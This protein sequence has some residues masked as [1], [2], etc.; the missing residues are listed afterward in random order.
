MGSNKYI[1]YYENNFDGEATMA[2]DE[3]RLESESI[4][5]KRFYRRDFLASATVVGGIGLAGCA[6]GESGSGDSDSGGSDSDSTDSNSDEE[7]ESEVASVELASGTQGTNAYDSGLG[8]LRAVEEHSDTL[9]L[10]I[11]EGGG[12]V[13]QAYL[14][15]N[16]E[17]NA[18]A[19]NNNTIVQAREEKGPFADEAVDI[20]PAQAHWFQSSHI[21]FLAREGSGVESLADIDDHSVYPLQPGWGARELTETILEEAGIAER[22]EYVNLDIGDMPGALA[23]GRVDV[24][25]ITAA[26]MIQWGGW[27][28]EMDVRNDLY[29]VETTDSYAQA[30][31]NH[32]G[33]RH[34]VMEPYGW[35]QDVT[36]ITNE[37]DTIVNDAQMFFGDEVSA[38]AVRELTRI[39]YEH[40]D[41]IR[42]AAKHYPE[43]D[44]PEE[45][46]NAVIK[47]HPIHEGAAEYYKEQEIWNDDW[48]IGNVYES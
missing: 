2:K 36:K 26:N 15:G 9:D 23:E 5:N 18:V 7:A 40:Q 37:I 41:T 20:V 24:T 28:Q 3:E 47:D 38:Q 34:I 25:A 48:T 44:G 10:T 32:P 29:V 33:A 31:K 19:L 12:Y 14:F 43:M 22:A 21:Y 45:L 27:V 42:E 30:I 13:N 46:T 39:A 16:G 35:E 11:T 1:C 6:G 4:R 8:I 17:I